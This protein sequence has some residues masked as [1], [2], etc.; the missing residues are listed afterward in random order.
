MILAPLEVAEVVPPGG[1]S[2]VTVT[3]VGT[4]AVWFTVDGTTPHTNDRR[5]HRV[6]QG[7]RTVA[8][9][10]IPVVKLVAAGSAQ[11]HVAFPALP[12]VPILDQVLFRASD[13]S[14]RRITIDE[15]GALITELVEEAGS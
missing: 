10:D 11:V 15:D 7:S 3:A 13:G 8:A 6:W 14:V 12:G 1:A 4:A 2:Q 9:D 5:A